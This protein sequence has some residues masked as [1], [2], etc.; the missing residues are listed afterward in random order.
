MNPK[1]LTSCIEKF[2]LDYLLSK[3]HTPLDK[4]VSEA[5]SRQKDVQL[6]KEISLFLKGDIPEHFNN[7]KPIFYLSRYI[8]SPDYET[9]KFYEQVKGYRLPVV[10]GEDPVDIFTTNSSLKRNL[11][12]MPI[13]NG[14]SKDG[15]GIIQY[16]TISDFNSQ[17]GKK[18][19]EVELLNHMKLH[20][21]HKKLCEKFLPKP[22][23]VVD[24]SKWVDRHSRGELVKLYED[25]MALFLVNGIMLEQYEPDEIDFLEEVV[26][27]ALKTTKERFG[28]KPLIAPLSLKYSKKI[29]DLNTYPASVGAYI[30]KEIEINQT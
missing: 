19:G 14:V 18:L 12:K 23:R 5:L 13:I 4:A 7:T 24:E 30:K 28:Y 11:M 1:F 16:T 26:L 6:R 17:Q 8:A 10:I 20:S 9:L 29:T 2:K 25:M 21:F 27:P 22:V 3:I 15:T